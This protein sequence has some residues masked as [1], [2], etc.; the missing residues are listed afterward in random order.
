MD[1]PL[2]TAEAPT[3]RQFAD[4]GTSIATVVAHLLENEEL[5]S[6]SAFTVHDE[7]ATLY[8]AGPVGQPITSTLAW[9]L[10]LSRRAWTVRFHPNPDGTPPHI[11]GLVCTGQ[12]GPEAVEVHRTVWGTWPEAMAASDSDQRQPIAEAA[13]V[14]MAAREIR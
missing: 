6:L 8:P 4:R 11:A 5:P 12:L 14:V 7:G 3:R 9:A 1:A 10:R 2:F 13:L